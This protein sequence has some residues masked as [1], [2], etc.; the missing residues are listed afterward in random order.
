MGW[1]DKTEVS[2]KNKYKLKSLSKRIYKTVKNGR[3]SFMPM[4]SWGFTYLMHD[5]QVFV[6]SP[7]WYIQSKTQMFTF[8]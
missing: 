3:L 4:Q 1:L 6:S 8:Q 2:T 7:S 5:F